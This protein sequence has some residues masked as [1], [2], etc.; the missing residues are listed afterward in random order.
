M[1]QR[2]ATLVNML[3]SVITVFCIALPT[4]PTSYAA[5]LPP[6][7][8][9]PL[10]PEL[11]WRKVGREEEQVSLGGITHFRMMGS[12][13]VSESLAKKLP[14]SVIA[15]YSS[16][17]LG[18]A[19]W[20]Y[21][22]DANSVSIM[23]R[24]Y[25]K[26][27]NQYLTVSMGGCLALTSSQKPNTPAPASDNCLRIWVSDAEAFAP[28]PPDSAYQPSETPAAISPAQTT[29]TYPNPLNVPLFSQN[30]SRWKA[31]QQGWADQ[32]TPTA[33]NY[34]TLGYVDSSHT[35]YG[36]WTT[37]YAMLYNYY[38]PN[39]TDPGNLNANLNMGSGGGPRYAANGSGCNNLM[40]WNAPY[41]P[42]GVSQGQ[43]LYN[44]CATTNCID[45]ITNTLLID[46]ELAAGRPLLVY[47][48]YSG[49]SPQHMVVITGHSGNTYFI[50][51]P[52][53]GAK[54][55][56]AS[57]GIAAYIVDWIYV[58]H[59]TPPAAL[60]AKFNATPTIGPH[61]L[62]VNFTDASVGSLTGR[63][64]SF[65][66]SMTSTYQNPTHTYWSTGSYTVSL[67]VTGPGGTAALT[68]THL[69]TVTAYSTYV[70][71]ICLP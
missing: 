52:W 50:N 49:Y 39:H 67:T 68:Q 8:A 6:E 60:A 47:V 62:T 53:N 29:T 4:T 10:Q 24:T 45:A 70:P 58:W 51:D 36:C 2:I 40:P 65:G 37:A 22:G 25:F 55:T 7:L 57:G 43:Y 56:L 42:S 17:N 46:S 71:L 23:I 31:N 20:R 21:L 41:A 16:Q 35:G 38:Q 9:A 59:G 26:A 27:P 48:H 32:A 34:S 44:Y 28:A 12:T 1:R 13:F 19:G 18:H 30:D 66:D 14:E 64:W 54:A 33:C 63:R 5:G 69:I 3:I 61:P 15:Y 11:I